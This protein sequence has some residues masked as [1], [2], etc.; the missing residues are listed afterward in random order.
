MDTLALKNAFIRAVRTFFQA[1]I[2]VF[3]LGASNATDL[4]SLVNTTLLQTAA[5]AGII[6]ALS[7]VMNM[8][9]SAASDPI[10]KG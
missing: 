7:F 2:P 4:T 5:L 3:I 9:E 1:A 10:P 8:L 6:A